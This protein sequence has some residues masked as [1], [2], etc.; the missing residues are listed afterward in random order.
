MKF[1]FAAVLGPAAGLGHPESRSQH[2]HPGRQVPVGTRGPLDIDGQRSAEI[3]E[4]VPI[5]PGSV[6]IS[7]ELLMV[8]GVRV[9]LNGGNEML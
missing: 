4:Q 3:T 7:R 2:V 5:T 9:S 8:L 6:K 1:P